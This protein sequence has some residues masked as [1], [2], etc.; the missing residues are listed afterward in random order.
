[1]WDQDTI[2]FMAFARGNS[3]TITFSTTGTTVT[4][5]I[6]QDGVEEPRSIRIGR[7]GILPG[8]LPLTLSE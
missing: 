1:V 4:F 3:E 7:H 2:D 6:L 8:R 5:D